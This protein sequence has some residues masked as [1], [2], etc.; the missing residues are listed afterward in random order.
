MISKA[1][2]IVA[3]LFSLPAAAAP[4]PANPYQKP[5][6]IAPG[7]WALMTPGRA[8]AGWF[9]FG[10]SVIAIDAGR[11]ADDARF[12]LKAIAST[13]GKSRVSMVILTSNFQPH[14]G[15]VPVFAAGGAAVLCQEKFGPS[16]LALVREATAGERGAPGGKKIS[17][18]GKT[19]AAA[20][21]GPVI[22]IA[23]RMVLA[24]EG[25]RVE[26]DFP[27]PADSGGDLTVYLPE[28]HVL[29]SGDL[30]E[31]DFLPLLFSK[32][33]D[34]DAWVRVL[35]HLSTLGVQAL[36][37]GYGPVGPSRGIPATRSYIAAAWEIAGKVAEQKV[38]D[39]ALA[40]R[41]GEPD[42]KLPELP[43]EL[44]DIHVKNV[45]AL[46]DRIRERGGEAPAN[47]AP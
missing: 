44:F 47:P 2:L 26:I 34:P 30:A 23:K 32:Q 13:A 21:V 7:V 14:A 42:V 25:R 5:K 40:M 6:E 17:A 4:A 36:V 39:D 41:L 22:T 45:K 3:F 46:A 15:G 16:V 24:G 20:P 8:N 29:F 18:K 11:S 33:I 19:E 12:I 28:D 31:N 37:P 43:P 1:A 9:R 10:N 35:D 38:P 27:G